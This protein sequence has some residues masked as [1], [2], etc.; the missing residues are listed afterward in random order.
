MPHFDFKQ[1]RIVHTDSFKVGTDAVL[2]GAW[3]ALPQTGNI[4]DVG[5]GSG[6]IT[7]MMAQR[8]YA[9]ITGIDIQENSI[10]E[11]ESNAKASPF[12][13][14][15]TFINQ[16][17]RQFSHPTPFDC[18]VT[19]PPYFEEDTAS[20]NPAE[21]LAKHTIGGLSFEE[22]IS[23]SARLLADGGSFQAVI[24]QN[25]YSRFTTL[26]QTYQ[27]ALK[28]AAS[29][30][31]SPRKPAKRCLLHF[32]KTAAHTEH[33]VFESICLQTSEGARSEAYQEM[34]KDFYLW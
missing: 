29:I 1:F 7:L 30:Q 3:A 2:L 24:P 13:E 20:H 4:L 6:I 28:R 34:T 11:A 10:V 14:R 32:V 21:N 17:I 16:D 9:H 12:A 26:A 19:N 23:H 5:C 22:L 31:T 15:I 27:F 18:I 8:S 33:P 25:V